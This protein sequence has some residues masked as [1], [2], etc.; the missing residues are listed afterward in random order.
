MR[1]T[2]LKRTIKLV[3]DVAVTLGL[4]AALPTYAGS[5]MI[6]ITHSAT[7]SQWAAKPA[8]PV[9][10]KVQPKPSPKGSEVQVAVMA[11]VPLQRA[12]KRS[13][14]IHR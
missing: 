12:A 13:V 9:A 5:G 4:L 3:L 6:K 11:K 2:S 7:C 8:R 1:T 10:A 14:F